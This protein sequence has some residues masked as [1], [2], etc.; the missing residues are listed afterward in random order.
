MTPLPCPSPA[1]HIAGQP[2]YPVSGR[3][4][5][6]SLP[7]RFLSSSIAPPSKTRLW[8]VTLLSFPVAHP[9]TCHLRGSPLCSFITSLHFPSSHSNQDPSPPFFAGIRLL[10]YISST[11]RKHFQPHFSEPRSQG[12]PGCPLRLSESPQ[13]DGRRQPQSRGSW[14]PPAR[15]PEVLVRVGVSPAPPHAGSRHTVTGGAG[16]VRLH[17]SIRV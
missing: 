1:Q 3:V 10:F 14:V 8:L 5:P 2:G 13:W 12:S 16:I 11:S 7:R 9:R 15:H 4:V 17:R 6:G